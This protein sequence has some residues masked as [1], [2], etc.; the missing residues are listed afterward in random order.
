MLYV[1]IMGDSCT[2]YIYRYVWVTLH[3]VYIYIY[4]TVSSLGSIDHYCVGLRHAGLLAIMMCTCG[5]Q[6]G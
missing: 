4:G 6:E 5:I 2:M 1:V 3:I